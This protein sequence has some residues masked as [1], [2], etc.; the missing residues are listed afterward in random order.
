MFKQIT[1]RRRS[2]QP[3]TQLSSEEIALF[4]KTHEKAISH[5]KP[6]SPKNHSPIDSLQRKLRKVTD[7]IK[8]K[9]NQVKKL[10]ETIDLKK[11][12]IGNINK[13]QNTRTI[14]TKRFYKKKTKL[15]AELEKAKGKY[16]KLL[17]GA[18]DNEDVER[19]KSR[20]AQLKQRL[21]ILNSIK[22]LTESDEKL[23][24]ERK[25]SLSESERHHADLSKQLSDSKKL[26][27]EL[28]RELRKEI[29]KNV[30][31]EREKATDLKS[32]KKMKAIE[33][34]YP[35]DSE[36]QKAK[37][38]EIQK[39]R[40]FRECLVEQKIYFD[41]KGK[42]VK[43]LMEKEKRKLRECNEGIE[44]IDAV[45]EYKNEMICGRKSIDLSSN[46]KRLQS[47]KGSQVLVEILSNLSNEE[48]KMLLY[49]FFMKIMD[50][51]E[52][53]SNLESL[54]SYV[55]LEKDDLEQKVR[56][57]RN[58]IQQERLEFDSKMLA[59]KKQHEGNMNL[60]LQH[61]AVDTSMSGNS[62]IE[63]QRLPLPPTFGNTNF[64]MYNNQFQSRQG[65]IDLSRRKDREGKN[66]LFS[67]LNMKL[68]TRY[69][70]SSSGNNNRNNESHPSLPL[71]SLRQLMPPPSN[72]PPMKVTRQKNKIIIEDSS[73]K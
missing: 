46:N 37:R 52:S 15:E 62:S 71:D 6:S 31:N 60:M 69:Q 32:M 54:L 47:E 28:S 50:L 53:S 35:G 9:T 59:L 61:F 27:E 44:A 20:I 56:Y 13:T 58:T 38:Y 8:A 73:R 5:A 16:H 43:G 42:G 70:C 49:K 57:L 14:V 51:K 34:K 33:D 64:D 24:E 40:K 23:K 2:I 12:L 66:R 72:V 63:Q 26:Y 41:Q 67:N 11:E 45:I 55:E 30:K 3:G 1:G 29:E 7:D 22:H 18:K 65:T 68:L 48:M 19:L 4:N 10:K 25:H 36:E 39:L 21:E 17:L